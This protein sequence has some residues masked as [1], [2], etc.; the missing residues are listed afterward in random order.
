MEKEAV[1]RV[2]ECE[3]ERGRGRDM[4]GVE[5]R[6][7]SGDEVIGSDCTRKGLHLLLEILK[8]RRACCMHET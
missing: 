4:N 2:L 1:I 6:L 5:L 7:V 3:N 8:E